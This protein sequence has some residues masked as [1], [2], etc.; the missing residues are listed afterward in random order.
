MAGGDKNRLF[1][2]AMTDSDGELVDLLVQPRLRELAGLTV[3]RVWPT[4]RR[5]LIG[6]FVFF[7][8]MQRAALPPG[9]GLGQRWVYVVAGTI[10]I[11]DARFEAGRMLVLAD[12]VHVD[13]HAVEAAKLMLLGV[14]AFR[15]WQNLSLLDGPRVRAALR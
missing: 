13:V 9:V 12:G 11:G 4:A 10:R 7:D 3:N 6:P 1:S 15:A 8:H 14:A 5:R 2:A